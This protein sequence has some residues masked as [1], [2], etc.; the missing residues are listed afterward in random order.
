MALTCDVWTSSNSRQSESFLGVTTHYLTPNDD[1]ELHTSLLA[2][3]EVGEAHTAPN[4][5]RWFTSIMEDYELCPEQIVACVTDNGLNM[6]A[7]MQILEN[8]YGWAH[9]RCAAH[10]LQLCVQDCLKEDSNSRSIGKCNLRSLNLDEWR[11][12]VAPNVSDRTVEFRFVSCF[13]HHF[14]LGSN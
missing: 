9:F 2:V 1:A 13:F 8:E 7:A 4:I 14:D 12:H 3:K 6:V 10:T 11:K 5:A